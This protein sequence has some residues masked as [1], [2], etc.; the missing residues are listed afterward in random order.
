MRIPARSTFAAALL[1]STAL[2]SDLRNCRSVRP[3]IAPRSPSALA[4]L[5]LNTLND[6]SAPELASGVA[7]DKLDGVAHGA[8][9]FHHGRVDALFEEHRRVNGPFVWH[10]RAEAHARSIEGA[11]SAVAAQDREEDLDVACGGR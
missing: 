11:L 6:L 9:L 5:S 3:R 4:S 10:A 1:S 2:P 7:R 8:Q